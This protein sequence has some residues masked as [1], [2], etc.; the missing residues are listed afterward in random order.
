MSHIHTIEVQ[1][2]PAIVHRR[3]Y[4]GTTFKGVISSFSRNG[5]ALDISADTFDLYL[6][7]ENDGELY[8]LIV[9][10]G[11]TIDGTAGITWKF[12]DAQTAT[13]ERNAKYSYLIKWTEDAT[14]DVWPVLAGSVTP[15]KFQNT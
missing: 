7:D 4:I 8:H 2:G 3:P 5:V 9:G 11:I 10:D 13:F 6:Y 14:G 1:D 12:T 15:Q